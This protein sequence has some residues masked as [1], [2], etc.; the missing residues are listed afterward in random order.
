MNSNQKKILVIPALFPASQNDNKGIFVWDY[1]KSVQGSYSVAVYNIRLFGEAAG[2]SVENEW[3]ITIH[4]E[5]LFKPTKVTKA[6][7]HLL[8]LVWYIKAIKYLKH[9]KGVDLIHVHG[10]LFLNGVLGLVASSR[11]KA[12]VVYSEHM[13][14]FY[15]EYSNPIVRT[16]GQFIFKRFVGVLLVSNYLRRNV[17]RRGFKPKQ[18]FV[19]YNPVDTQQFLPGTNRIS[20]RLVFVGRFDSN[21]GPIRVLEAF[22]RAKD[23]N[24]EL[25]LVM[26][27]TGT[28][29]RLA[30]EFLA[31]NPDL[32]S[33]IT[34]LGY[35]NKT[36]INEQLQL[37]SALVSPSIV[38]SFGISVAEAMSCG[39]P[40]IVGKN[41]GPTE[42]VD[43][44]SG[45]Q[46]NPKDIDE[47]AQ[48]M[49]HI[50]DANPKY[51]PQYIRKNITDRFSLPVFGERLKE[52]YQ[53]IINAH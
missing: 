37:A 10:G 19:V 13:G 46:V 8:Y 33:S 3:G 21:R 18:T 32:K 24:H 14:R 2:V 15:E 41:T 4:R 12:P 52:V 47:I 44:Q 30:E 22:K 39:I 16:A 38:E 7:K 42:F 11:L 29:A 1:I 43:P 23:T 51:D 31:N 5:N 40:V 35:Q 6:L 27:G 48:A 25:S 34:L 50:T 9:F 28:E 20:G 53:S 49:I 17:E 26:V 36:Q 45:I